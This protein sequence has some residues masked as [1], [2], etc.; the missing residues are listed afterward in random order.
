MSSFALR[1]LLFVFPLAG[2]SLETKTPESRTPSLIWD[3]LPALPPAPGQ[4]HQIGVAGPFVG[5]HNDVLIVAGGSNFP[6]GYPWEGGSKV[7]REDIFLLEE[8]PAGNV[9]WSIVPT[10]LPRPMGHG[11]SFNTSKGVIFVGGADSERCYSDVFR[12]S[13]DP[14]RRALRQSTLPSL[15]AP[16]A[17]MS[18]ALVGDILYLT[19]GQHRTQNA[20]LEPVFWALD[21]RRENQPDFTWRKLPPWPGPGRILPVTVSQIHEGHQQLFLFSGRI[22]GLNQST[23]LLSDAYIYDPRTGHWKTLGPI[24]G[25]EGI[26]VMAGTALAAENGDILLVGGSRGARFL[27][28]ENYDLALASLRQ[29]SEIASPEHASALKAAMEEI[30]QKKLALYQTHTGF[31]RE[32]LRFQPGTASW[33][34]MDP[35]PFACPVTTLAVRWKE[36]WVIPSGETKPGVRTPQILR[37]RIRVAP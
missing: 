11:I 29:Q 8:Q 21:L 28:L 16:L 32:I 36:S 6:A 19:G 24:G 22:P 30:L 5:V 2:F 25:N 31:S 10:K 12:Y 18:G 37:A 7:W 3:E 1:L 20:P 13:W 35:L 23:T 4:S 34:R 17:F 9:I 26:C 14:E 27:Q 15:P 33:S